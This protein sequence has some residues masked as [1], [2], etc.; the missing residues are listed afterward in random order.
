M[1]R[2]HLA[3]EGNAARRVQGY[4]SA[5]RWFAASYLAGQPDKASW[6]QVDARD[7]QRWMTQLLHRHARLRH[8]TT[9]LDRLTPAALS[10]GVQLAD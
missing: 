9:L 10:H 5:V 2:N 6:E 3:A 7:I 4:T 1:A 8:L